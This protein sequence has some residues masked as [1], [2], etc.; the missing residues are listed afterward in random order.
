MSTLTALRGPA[1]V[2][3]RQHRWTLWIAGGLALL[4]VAGLI[5]LALRSAHVAEVFAASECR[6]DGADGNR[7]CM[8]VASNYLDSMFTYRRLFEDVALALMALPVLLSGFV[9]GPLIARE[10]ET[11]TFKVSW[12]QS[13]SPARWLA[14]ELAVPAVLLLAGTGVLSASLHLA[15]SHADGP[16]P[17]E[18]HAM[19][20]FSTTGTVL[21][22]HVL[23][24][25]CVGA[26][27]GILVRRTLLALTLSVLVTGA[28]G[29][30]FAG[31][32]AHLWPPSTVSGT[33]LDVRENIWWVGTGHLTGTGE[34]LSQDVCADVSE[35][36]RARCFADNGITGHY[37][38]YHPASHFWPLQLVETG[39]LLAL[40]AAAVTVAFRLL[41]RRTG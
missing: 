19:H 29:V 5:A 17:S 7:E 8:Q 12:T 1:R 38:D 18:W 33:S 25:L 16:Y 20:V 31:L 14:A 24:A 39:I 30:A 4:T 6:T 41:R 35:S 26:L 9:A 22:G 36:A 37:L 23:F 21:A 10:L 27:I 15:R 2:V 34:R 3:V 28:V 40:A 32:R 11:G 13:V